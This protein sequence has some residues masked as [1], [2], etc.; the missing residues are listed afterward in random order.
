MAE[1]VLLS[2][3][4]TLSNNSRK[5]YNVSLTHET[6]RFSVYHRLG[7]SD[8]VGSGKSIDVKDI[9]GCVFSQHLNTQATQ[10][11]VYAYPYVNNVSCCCRSNRT[12]R[13]QEVT[14]VIAEPEAGTADDTL[15]VCQTWRNVIQRLARGENFPIKGNL[16]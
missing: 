3:V 11:T 13:R 16:I 7:N 14:F 6:L 12:R 1:D 2:G 4:F 9:T 10:F 8:P 15:V 5:R